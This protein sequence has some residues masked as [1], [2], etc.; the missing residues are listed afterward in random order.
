MKTSGERD[1]LL[2]RLRGQRRH[3]VEQLD[4]LSEAQLRTSSLPSGWT[5]LGLVRHLTLSDERYW[6]EVVM[7][8]GPLD[9]WPP[10]D[11][12]DWLV[13]ADESAAGV[14]DAYRVAAAASDALIEA[15]DL[16]APPRRPESWWGQAG[17]AFPTCGRSSCTYS[18]RPPPTPVTSTRPANSSTAG[19]TWCCSAPPSSHPSTIHKEKRMAISLSPYLNFPGNG[20]EAMTYY[21]SVFGGDLQLF[22]F[23]DYGMTDMP[24]D[25][26]MHGALRGDGFVISASDAMPGA[27]QTWG[28]T[29]VY[30]AFF[31]DDLDT[32]KGWFEALAAD[33]SVGMALEKQI[34]GDIY[35]IVKDKYGIEW[36]FNVSSPEGEA[37]QPG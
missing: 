29:R 8:S 32:M 36:M 24:E 4:G 35:G 18:S 37:Q 11:N 13:G 17:L 5:P 2:E 28:G 21:H 12:A 15:T 16:D 19:S 27:E 22:G 20:R 7:A 23:G 33:G 3:V 25:G 30:C 1:L 34:W 26:L 14:I 9:F 10:G 6:F 31:G